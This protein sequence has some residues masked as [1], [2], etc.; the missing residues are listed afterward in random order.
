MSDQEI[1]ITRI[2]GLTVGAIV[3]LLLLVSIIPGIGAWYT[4]ED[5]NRAVETQ[6]GQIEESNIGPGLHFKLPIV[7]S[8]SRYNVRAQSYTM[9]DSNNRSES[10][11]SDAIDALT[12]EGLNIRISMTVRYNIEP[13]KT[14]YLYENVGTNDDEVRSTLVR[15]TV[16][17][18][19]RTS[20][21]NYS[22]ESIYSDKRSEFTA[23]IKD[24][25]RTEFENK[26]LNV[27]AIQVRNIMLPSSVRTAIQEKQATQERIETKENE[28]E[29]SELEKERK[30]IEAK[31]IAQSNQ[32][33]GASLSQ[34]YLEWYWIQEGLEKGDGMYVI[35]NAPGNTPVGNTS[36]GNVSFGNVTNG[37][38][39]VP[40][41]PELVKDIDSIGNDG[42]S[43][44]EA[45]G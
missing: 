2:A 41:G 20:S 14:G 36:A 12:N 45:S 27:Q 31:G 37:N 26:G 33:I 4:V 43:G 24:R 3:G 40:Q 7:D 34:P 23:N 9:S 21:A 38:V 22:V 15:P 32:I 44:A 35:R 29:I 30:V 19:I 25:V 18:A 8:V 6:F 28:L 39:S 42:S 13:N 16:R 1:S 5:G 11:E 10:T 17:T